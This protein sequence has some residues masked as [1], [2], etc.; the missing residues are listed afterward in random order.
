MIM[1][2]DAWDYPYG[3]ELYCSVIPSPGM[4]KF[5]R[6]YKSYI[7]DGLL[8][9]I[10]RSIK[11][12]SDNY[13]LSYDSVFGRQPLLADAGLE[14]DLYIRSP[15]TGQI[16]LPSTAGLS[17]RQIARQREGKIQSFRRFH[18]ELHGSQNLRSPQ[19][20]HDKIS[21][22]D[23]ETR[24]L[25]DKIG[26]FRRIRSRTMGIAGASV[27]SSALSFFSATPMA[28]EVSAILAAAGGMSGIKMWADSQ[29]DMSSLE[30]EN[31]WFPWVLEDSRLRAV[32]R[33]R[34]GH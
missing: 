16:Y 26:R 7:L 32:G 34:I 2:D 17:M 23:S 25:N 13:E 10:P 3:S 27:L 1:F 21:R 19:D 29:R 28:G 5:I 11:S 6:R 30:Q 9:P 31:F 18:N 8:L 33:R 20:L 12:F 4:V 14:R 15:F 22:T 24:D